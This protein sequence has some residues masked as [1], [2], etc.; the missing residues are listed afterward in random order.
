MKTYPYRSCKASSTDG[1]ED[2]S[3]GKENSGDLRKSSA[4]G[5]LRYA[6][7]SNLLVA[8]T[9]TQP[10]VNN[11]LKAGNSCCV[12][13]ESA[14]Q[15]EDGTEFLRKGKLGTVNRDC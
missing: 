7:G 13:L 15:I 10:G 14:V 11:G 2:H 9:P 5:D 8:T 4:A 3:Y 1:D 12:N 6:A